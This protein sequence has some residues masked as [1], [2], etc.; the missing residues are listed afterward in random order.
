MRPIPP[1]AEELTTRLQARTVLDI[2]VPKVLGWQGDAENPVQSEYM[3][4]EEAVGVPLFTVWDDMSI[5]EKEAI[6]DEVIGIEKKLLSLS[7]SRSVFSI[8][9]ILHSADKPRFSATATFTT[10]KTLVQSAKSSK[11]QGAYRSS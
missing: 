5:Y 7:F 1:L 8:V 4:T 2:P 9:Q 11:S 6:V 10:L 3:L